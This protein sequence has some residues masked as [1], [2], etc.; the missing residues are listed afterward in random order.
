MV[1]DDAKLLTRARQGDEPS[2]LDLYQ[3]YRRPVFQFA[4]RLTGSESAA[5]DVVQESFLALLDGADYDPA[6][7]A[8]RT[9]LLGIARHRAMR[10]LRMAE[11]EADETD[12]NSSPSAEPDALRQLLQAERAELVGRAISA[13]PVAQR[14]ALVLF[15]YED[16]SLDEIAKVTGS[17]SGAVKARLFRA[18]ETLRKRLL[19]LLALP[20]A[21]S[22]P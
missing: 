5:E 4:W 7:G 8:L 20:A 11:R 1:V 15:E 19:P 14:E 12:E 18:R 6:H 13:L 16:L 21:R 3:R 17:E 9:Y 10:R 2:F 22:S